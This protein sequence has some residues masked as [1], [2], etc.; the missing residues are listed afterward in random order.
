MVGD[1]RKGGE[2]EWNFIEEVESAFPSNQMK[3]FDE[4]D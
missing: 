2:G 3:L 4:N 1:L